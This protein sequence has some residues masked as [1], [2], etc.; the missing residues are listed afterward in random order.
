MEEKNMTALVSCFARA[1]H[2]RNSNIK[3]YEDS[4]AEMI[5]SKK[6]Y[7]NISK[8]MSNGI[9]FFNPNFIGTEQ[10]A[11]N[12]I[13]NNDLAPSV[14]ARSIF[15]VKSIQNDKQL[16][17][18]QYLIFASGY[19]TYGYTDKEIRCYE[20][21]KPNM[22]KDKIQRVKKANIDYSNV[23]YIETDFSTD[24]WE[25]SLISSDIDWNKKVFCSLLGISYYLTKNEFFNMIEKISKLICKDSTIV[26][27]YPTIEDS[28]KQEITRNL[29]KGANE[30]MKAKYNYEELELKFEE[31]N[32]LICKHLNYE[33]INEQYFKEYNLKSNNKIFAPKGVNYC[34]IVKR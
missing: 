25:N 11:L 4:L 22:I 13:V 14:L 1:Y 19:D 3:I 5:L 15:T 33:D 10:E 2:N 18:E 28:D 16:G 17:L 34:L 30:E 23:R 9:K 32:L 24:N 27:D 21:D 26:F 31:Y 7:D 8:N 20:I 12:W 29:A 6:E